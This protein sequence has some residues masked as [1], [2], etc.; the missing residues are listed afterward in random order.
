M[1]NDGRA[2]PRAY[3]YLLNNNKT[4]MNRFTLMKLVMAGGLLLAPFGAAAADNT[5]PKIIIT[6]ASGERIEFLLANNPVITFQDNVL[7]VE[8]EQGVNIEVEAEEVGGFNFVPSVVT[9]IESATE[10]S[11]DE[12]QLVGSRIKGLQPGARVEVF[13]LDG[14]KADTLTAGDNGTVVVDFGQLKAGVYVI[15]TPHGS[16]KASLKR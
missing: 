15:K 4:L 6:T 1:S 13:T 12:P 9:N 11:A 8:D 10:V 2:I 3:T 7:H 14:R 16:F 5:E